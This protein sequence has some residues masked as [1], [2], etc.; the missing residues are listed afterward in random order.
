MPADL[1]VDPTRLSYVVVDE[2]VGDTVTLAVSVW[3]GLGRARP[4]PLPRRPRGA[5]VG[6]VLVHRREL[7]ERL[8]EGWLRRAPRVGD[9]FAAVLGATA[10]ARLAASGEVVLDADLQLADAFPGTVAD[11]TA[12]ARNVAKLAFFAAVAGVQPHAQAEDLGQVRTDERGPPPRTRQVKPEPRTGPFLPQGQRARRRPAALDRAEEALAARR[13]GRPGRR[14]PRQP[15]GAR[16][17]SCSTSATA[18][19]SS[20]CCPRSGTRRSRR[21]RCPAARS[22]STPARRRSCAAS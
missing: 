2:I 12:E 16:S 13:R 14:D 17:T 21:R 19:P 5:P 9:A 8:Y 6:H 20:C 11:L 3:P 10:A 4:G 7:H 22:S 15:D 18:T 1:L